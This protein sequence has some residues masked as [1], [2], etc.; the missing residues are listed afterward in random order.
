MKLDSFMQIQL[1][2]VYRGLTQ[3][4]DEEVLRLYK[5]R[6]IPIA[7]VEGAGKGHIGSDA[8]MVQL[9]DLFSLSEMSLLSNVTEFFERNGVDYHPEILFRD[10]KVR[11]SSQQSLEYS[12]YTFF[13]MILEFCVSMSSDNAS[14]CGAK[15]VRIH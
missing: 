10:I 14:Y 9:A 6:V 8:K 13:V 5:N 2:S 15:Y 11:R 3:L 12:I 7:Y 1:G 4:S